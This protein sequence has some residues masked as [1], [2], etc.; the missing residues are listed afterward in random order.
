MALEG[1]GD[2]LKG[3]A[4]EAA[5]NITDDKSLE[6]EGKANQLLGDVK[7]KLSD[8][9]DAIK[10]KANEVAAKVEDKLGNDG[11]NK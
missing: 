8:A 7:E 9:G 5:G 11:E 2:Q 3:A 10:D 6:N 4:K 1:A